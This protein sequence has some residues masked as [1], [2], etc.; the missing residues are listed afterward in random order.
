MLCTLPGTGSTDLWCLAK[1]LFRRYLAPVGQAVVGESQDWGCFHEGGRGMGVHLTFSVDF[2]QIIL[3][4]WCLFRENLPV[5]FFALD[6]RLQALTVLT[7]SSILLFTHY[8]RNHNELRFLAPLSC[9][10][11][12]GHC[13]T[14]NRS[15]SSSRSRTLSTSP[16]HRHAVVLQLRQEGESR[17][18]YQQLTYSNTRI[19][20]HILNS[21]KQLLLQ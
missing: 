9:V 6:H 19:Q 7:A 10:L 13:S 5:L 8:S 17:V 18:Y 21:L 12:V 14:P 2:H 1:E 15:T 11:A 16:S 4:G 20:V 3:G